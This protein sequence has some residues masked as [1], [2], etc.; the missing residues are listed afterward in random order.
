MYVLQSGVILNAL[1]SPVSEVSSPGF[2]CCLSKC[3]P[4]DEETGCIRVVTIWIFFFN[5]QT[6]NSV[7]TISLVLEKIKNE[8]C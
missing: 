1:Q 2:E 5:F 6:F 3:G 8:T 4:T 7:L